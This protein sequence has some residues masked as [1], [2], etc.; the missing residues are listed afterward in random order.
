MKAVNARFCGIL[1]TCMLLALVVGCGS[2]NAGPSGESSAP[3]SQPSETSGSSVQPCPTPTGVPSPS[4][5]DEIAG[6]MKDM[7]LEQK[8]GQL[9]LAGIDGSSID[10]AMKKMIAEQHVGGI[11]LYK[12]N[13]SDLEGSVGLV[14][15]LKKANENNPVPLFMSVDQE[16]G[17]VN[18]LPKDFVA[19]PD[20]AKVGKSGDPKL[21]Q[22]MGSLLSEELRI[23]GF[24]VDF[25]PVLDINSN[26]KNPVI[27]SRAFGSDAELVTKMGVAAMKGLQEGGTIAVVKHFPGHG[28]TAVDSHLDLPVVHKTT[29]QL[30]TMEWVPFRTAIEEG[31]DA[32]MVAHILFPAVDPDAPASFSKVIIGEQLR[33]TLG[34]DG[35][36]ITDDM[37]MGAITQHYGLEDAAL[38]SIEAGSDI[39]LVAHGYDTEK[40]VYDSLLQAVKSGRLD[41]SRVDES[42]RRI[43]TLKLKYRLNDSP[44]PV[45]AVADLPNEAIRDWQQELK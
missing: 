33:G 6:M 31:A 30:Q 41:E 27:G 19:I 45:P 22:R 42:V 24:N 12:N 5:E 40:K 14:N 8:I 34:F 17:K 15:A 39:I 11:I 9:I 18:R 21:A 10:A 23:M 4:E 25:A 28:D 7:T 43:L 35:V 29:E 36:I 44:V 2:G 13:F 16:G 37:T 3:P 20:A 1:C 26:P 32:V 38:K